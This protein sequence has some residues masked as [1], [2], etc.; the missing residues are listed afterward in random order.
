[1]VTYDILAL[2]SAWRVYTVTLERGA[3]GSYL[4][5]VHELPGC[6][7]RAATRDEVLARL[8]AAIGEFEAWAGREPLA[9]P[10]V[11]IAD[12]VESQIEADEDT[13][14]LV[15]PDQ[16][17]L[18]PE[19]WRTV[20]ELLE[21]SRRDLGRLLDSLDDA[22]LE[23]RRPGSERTLRE[24]LEHVAFVELMYAMWTFD[25]RSREGLREFLDWARGAA[26]GR[27]RALAE[28]R[29]GGRTEADWAGAPRP[30]PWTARKAARRLVWHELLHAEAIAR[31]R[32]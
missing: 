16:E 21:R 26:T 8:P 27:M 3:D 24:E 11:R 4:A 7:V 30:E 9:S 13:E 32:R 22:E 14:V 23:T 10:D 15:Q 20:E 1:L 12:E 5:W 2:R 31:S 6:A 18:T 28:A 29:S 17:P 25:L 19:Y